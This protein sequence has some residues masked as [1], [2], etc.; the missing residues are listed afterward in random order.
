MSASESTEPVRS[1]V[2][3]APRAVRRYSRAVSLTRGPVNTRLGWTKYLASKYWA[4][5]SASGSLSGPGP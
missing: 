2:P 4:S 3:M 5:E 1:P